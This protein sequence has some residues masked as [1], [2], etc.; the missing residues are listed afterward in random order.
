MSSLKKYGIFLASGLGIYSLIVVSIL[1]NGL[2]SH[3]I[4]TASQ[5]ASLSTKY[6]NLFIGRGTLQPLPTIAGG[7]APSLLD[8]DSAPAQPQCAEGMKQLQ[9]GDCGNGNAPVYTTTG[10]AASASST[11]PGTNSDATS[12][13]K[14]LTTVTMSITGVVCQDDSVV[15]FTPFEGC[16]TMTKEEWGAQLSQIHAQMM[17]LCAG[18]KSQACSGGDSL[19]PVTTT[20]AVQSPVT[21]PATQVQLNSTGT[22]TKS[23]S[24]GSPIVPLQGAEA[25]PTKDRGDANCD[26][27]IDLVDFRIWA[28]EYSTGVGTS[29]DFNGDGSV[30]FGDFSIWRDNYVL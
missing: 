1:I 22:T 16:Q 18:K 2:V 14:P 17:A 7:N 28:T 13:S 23:V 8:S 25:C 19:P 27:L 30:S 5:A 24:G 3:P 26:G 12:V 11:S 29:A 6:K 20:P 21:K 4:T 10:G 9:F 15:P